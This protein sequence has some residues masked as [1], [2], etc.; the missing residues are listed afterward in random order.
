MPITFKTSPHIKLGG[1]HTMDAKVATLRDALSAHPDAD[2]TSGIT[3]TFLQRGGVTLR[4]PLGIADAANPGK[5][6][7]ALSRLA[8]LFTPGSLDW[9]TGG[10]PPAGLAAAP[11]LTFHNLS[12]DLATP[13]V[14]GLKTGDTKSALLNPM[15]TY[16]DMSD[17]EWVEAV[18]NSIFPAAIPLHTASTLYQTVVG[19]SGGSIYRCGFI[20][21]HLRGACRIKGAS[22]AFRFTSEKNECPTGKAAE[23]LQRLGLTGVYPDRMTGHHTMPGPYD[24]AHAHEYRAV[25]GAYYAALR[26]WL[27]SQFPA[28]GK[29]T[30]GVA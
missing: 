1:D 27:T 5:I 21:P 16:D 3:E 13:P 6:T 28:I 10:T 20:G 30:D 26:P 23:T 8:G 2:V 29:F 7:L 14:Q 4:L 12:P 22:I 15:K 24:E 17:D 19:T 18:T 9:A 11:G 25:F